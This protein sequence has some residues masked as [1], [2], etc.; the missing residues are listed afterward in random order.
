[1]QFVASRKLEFEM[2]SLIDSVLAREVLPLTNGQYLSVLIPLLL[3]VI[4]LI[5]PYRGV[6]LEPAR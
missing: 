6:A 2:L 1:M 4:I 3:V 5:S